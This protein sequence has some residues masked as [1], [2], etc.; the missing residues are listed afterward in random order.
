MF[1]TQ[2]LQ[3]L[4]VLVVCHDLAVGRIISHYLLVQRTMSWFKAREFCQRHYVDLTVLSK[5]EQYFTLLNATATN[6]VSF[7]L[8]L[9]RQTTFSDWMWVNGE[10]LRYDDWFRTNY[11][12]H[13]ASLDAM[14]EKEKKLLARHCDE[15]HMIACQGPV[16]PQPVSVDSVDPDHVILSWNV[17]AFM[18]MTAH[19]Y[20]VTTCTN[21][22]NT[23]LYP[24]TDGSAFM[25]INI[26]N[27]TSATEYFIEVS[28]LVVRPDSVT[29]RNVTLQ[30]NPT[31]LRV[32]AGS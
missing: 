27:L 11:E 14:L 5:E 9:Q 4:A 20:N 22:C 32:K 24:N 28:A 18:Q 8:G 7:W 10:E 25:N 16:S 13:C 31:A 17:S 15:S 29:G 23:L 2:I 3:R 19:S 21:T 1:E 12:G 6:N 26:S 30:S